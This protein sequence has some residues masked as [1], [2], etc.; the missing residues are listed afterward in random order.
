[1]KRQLLIHSLSE[2]QSIYLPILQL[3]NAKKIGEIGV[4]F[5]GNTKVLIELLEKTHGELFS[6]DPKPNEEVETLFNQ[7]S[8]ANLFKGKSLDVITELPSMCAWFI[9]GD[10]NWY[11]VF[12]ELSAIHKTEKS[13]AEGHSVIFLH[14]IGFPWAFRD[15]YYNPND[16]P[17]EYL[18]PHCWESGVLHDNTAE[19]NKGF[20]GMGHFAI[21]TQAGGDKNGVMCAVND[22][23]AQHSDAYSFYNIPAVFGLGILVPKSH[24]FH[25]EIHSIVLPY[26]DNPLLKKLEEN[27]LD[28]YLKVIELQDA[29]N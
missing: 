21:A 20:R 15:L 11:T 17:S 9:D 22:F 7:H 8:V 6:I 14:D 4:E 16:I 10:H 19:K 1:M 3:I 25:N 27:R 13:H 29:R 26:V 18:H 28:N 5:A 2:L 12:N 23:L 24:K